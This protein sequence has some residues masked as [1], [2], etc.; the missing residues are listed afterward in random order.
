LTE[1]RIF[2]NIADFGRA[3]TAFG[4]GTNF[5]VESRP[6]ARVEYADRAEL[7]RATRTIPIVFVNIASGD[8]AGRDLARPGGNATGFMNVNPNGANG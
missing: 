3:S 8:T 7:Q 1:G 4:R 2:D 5:G 6:G